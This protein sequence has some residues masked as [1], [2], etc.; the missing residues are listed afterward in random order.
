MLR[1][2][3]AS[4]YNNPMDYTTQHIQAFFGNISHQTVKNWCR[5]FAKWLSPTATPGNNKQRR[6]TDDDLSVFALAHEMLN[7]GKTYEDVQA[8]LA[9]GSRGEIP[10]ESVDL[11]P[12]PVSGQVLAL[13]DS[14]DTAHSEIRRLQSALDEQRGRDKLLE[15]QLAAAQAEIKALN[16]EIGRLEASKDSE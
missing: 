7:K 6:F 8:A 2:L 10:S 4:D 5:E 3:A 1:Q 13:R 16:R 11:L 14:L 15:E 9:A 12:A